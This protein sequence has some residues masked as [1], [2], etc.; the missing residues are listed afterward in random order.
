MKHK[1]LLSLAKLKHHC[2]WRSMLW[3]RYDAVDAALRAA[4]TG[5]V[6]HEILMTKDPVLNSLGM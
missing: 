1:R 3:S 2:N 4:V 5:P 6:N